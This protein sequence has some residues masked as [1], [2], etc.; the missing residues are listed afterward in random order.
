MKTRYGRLAIAFG[1]LT[2]A[3]SFVPNCAAQCGGSPQPKALHKNSWF[4]QP[5]QIRFL[6]AAFKPGDDENPGRE[7]SIVG[8]WHVKFVSK[9]SSG[10]PD[11]TE[12]DAGYSQ[13]HSDGTEI[14]NSGAQPPNTSNFCLG[15]WEQVA[16]R[17]YKLNHFA[18]SWDPSANQL[19]GPA[20][21]RE[22]V[23]L[24]PDGKKFNGTFTIDQYDEKLNVL[25][26]VTGEITG[27]RIEVETPP[28]S[29]F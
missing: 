16:H 11:G 20:H 10:I 17:E 2:V 28:Q 29:I 5:G 3:L 25:A 1:A 21:I 12:V 23:T 19:V 6:S 18:V 26:H 15:V 24:E 4:S 9:D 13:W 7:P 27:T 14:L 22:K 8:L